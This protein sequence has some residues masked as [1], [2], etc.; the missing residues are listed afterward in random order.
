MMPGTRLS[1]SWARAEGKGRRGGRPGRA[2]VD[3]E[4]VRDLAYYPQV[5]AVLTVPRCRPGRLLIPGPGR[6]VVADLAVQERAVGPQSQP[7][8]ACAVP[9]RV[10]G[11]LM[12][13]DHDV[14]DP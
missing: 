12:R 11:Q 3:A 1:W 10:G 2:M 8:A 9:D 13:G 6:A 7:P 4:L 5:M 14:V